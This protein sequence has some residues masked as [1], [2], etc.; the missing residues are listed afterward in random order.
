MDSDARY[1]IVITFTARDHTIDGDLC[2]RLNFELAR[3][4]WVLFGLRSV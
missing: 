3:R 2:D 4:R 1:T